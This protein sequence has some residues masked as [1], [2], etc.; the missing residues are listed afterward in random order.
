MFQAFN[1]G[2]RGSSRRLIPAFELVTLSYK[3]SGDRLGLLT[4]ALPHTFARRLYIDTLIPKPSGPLW[5][6][7]RR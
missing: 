7:S 6:S 4:L 1:C 2:V 3:A 5:E